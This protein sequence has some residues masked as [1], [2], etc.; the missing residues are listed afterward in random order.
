MVERQVETCVS[1]VGERPGTEE[2]VVM[3]QIVQAA[4]SAQVS[5]ETVSRGK[6]R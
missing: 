5:P 3:S 1:L 4:F 2:M 6:A